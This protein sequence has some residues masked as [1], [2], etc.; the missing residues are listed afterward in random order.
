MTDSIGSLT[1]SQLKEAYTS[2]SI[3]PV[4]AISNLIDEIEKRFFFVV[5][6][7]FYFLLLSTHTSKTNIC[8]VLQQGYQIN[9][10]IRH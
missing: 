10:T 6:L 7:F 2:G 1:I 5:V 3:S 4:D 9:H 8:S